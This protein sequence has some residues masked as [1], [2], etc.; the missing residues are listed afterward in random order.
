MK[1]I[2]KYIEVYRRLIIVMILILLSRGELLSQKL[3]IASGTSMSGSNGNIII[4]TDIINNGVFSNSEN[5]VV[6]ASSIQTISGDSSST[7]NDLTIK[8]GS[9][10]IV[11]TSRQQISGILLCNGILDPGGNIIL[12]STSSKTALIDGSGTGEVNSSL[13]VQRYLPSGMGYKYLSS[14]FRSATVSELSDE[15]DLAAS[16]PPVYRFN[17]ARVG[18]GWVKY[19]DP[20]AILS[21]LQ[22]FSVN[23]GPVSTPVTVDISGVP[24]NGALTTTLYN[25]NMAYT[26]GFNLV[27]NPYASPID[28]DAAQ[29]WN[30]VNID[31]AV[32]YFNESSSDQY[33]GFYSTYMIGIS[34]NGVSNNIIPSMQGFFI[35]VSD[36]AFPV[37]GTFSL[38]NRVRIIDYT[39][40][41]S[42]SGT[43]DE[44]SIIRFF[45]SYSGKSDATDPFVVYYNEKASMNFDGRVDAL[46]MFNTSQTVPNFYVFDKSGKELSIYGMPVKGDSICTLRLGLKT[47]KDGMITINAQDISGIFSDMVIRLTDIISGKS[48]N[49]EH[50]TSYSVN[51]PAGDY[52]NRFFI[53]LSN[54]TTDLPL[55]SEESKSSFNA[56][57]CSGVLNVDINLAPDNKCKLIITSLNGHTMFSSEINESGHYEFYPHLSSGIYIVTA[58]SG[59]GK[60]SKKIAVI[61]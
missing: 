47:L 6:L 38:D 49:L 41:F 35:H 43:N 29:G 56:Y 46:K 33:S 14:P 1:S 53:N 9:S 21:P 5:K 30:R 37:T 23:L 19:V 10:V 50:G 61:N 15:I 18:S 26:K 7:F 17:E 12:R 55:T 59:T 58:F 51:L 13:I 31:N 48:V 20:S 24:N 16:F 22:G 25:N 39:H 52:Q 32:Y 4:M 40:P 42:K 2:E 3:V 34:S 8:S 28:W 36:G 11:T 60:E 44:K 27:G 54:S 45:A 57:H